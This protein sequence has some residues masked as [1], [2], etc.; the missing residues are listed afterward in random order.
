MGAPGTP[1]P[2]EDERPWQERA[3]ALLQTRDF[4]FR[5][6]FH[7]A[8]TDPRYLEATPEQIR[9]ELWAHVLV[10][11]LHEAQR[12]GRE[13]TGLEDLLPEGDTSFDE[14]LAAFDAQL[15][16]EARVKAKAQPAA[17]ARSE[18]E[19]VIAFRA[20]TA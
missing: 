3:W 11:R 9:T 5:R 7:L 20:P 16:S 10:G 6:L 12:E 17:P 8:P 19:P 13:V 2:R 1:A 15:E 18:L 14:Q 4:W